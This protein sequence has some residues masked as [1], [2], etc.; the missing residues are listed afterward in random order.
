MQKGHIGQI[1]VNTKEKYS[2]L[3]GQDMLDYLHGYLEEERRI[4]V[5]DS[6]VYNAHEKAVKEIAKDKK[7]IFCFEAGEKSKN[8]IT[9]H[10][11]Y[12]FLIEN[13]VDRYTY[14]VAFGGGVVGD[15]AAFAASTYMR[16]IPI[17]HVP[18]SLL[19]MV[20]SSIGGKTAINYHGL[21]NIVGSFY[22]PSLVLCDVDFLDTLPEREFNSALAEVVKYGIIADR[23]FFDFIEANKKNI[24]KRNKEI[25]VEMVVKSIENK[26][27]I[28]EADERE[29]N[30]RAALNFGHTLAHAV[31]SITNYSAYFHGEAV[32]VGEM[33]ASKISLKKGMLG[34]K[35]FERIKSL[36]SFFG[37]P[38]N[39]D[40]SF[41][42]EDLYNLMKKDK[43]SKKGVLRFVLTKKIGQFIITDDL[44]KSEIMDAIDE[45]KG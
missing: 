16:G 1:D 2:V 12:D 6:N 14:V 8:Y 25:L 30:I 41:G 15:I 20:D 11:I 27:K 36:L 44:D 32:A 37:L 39:I 45:L 19:A 23:E 40:R 31:E 21:K 38:T 10:S 34:I 7:G 17:V 3:V 33:L 29:G 5:S 26:V 24:K 4:V 43:K 35:D 22:Q 13:G 9:L 42:N 18:T 28:V